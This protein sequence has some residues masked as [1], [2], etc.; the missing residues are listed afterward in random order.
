MITFKS[1]I[2][3]YMRPIKNLNFENLKDQIRCL[4]SCIALC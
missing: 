3:T 2:D 1:D 4:L